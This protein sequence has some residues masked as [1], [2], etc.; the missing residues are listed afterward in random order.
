MDQ[1]NEEGSYMHPGSEVGA[2]LY[3]TG[4]ASDG[5]REVITDV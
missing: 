4:A 3:E 1:A 5:A 2:S